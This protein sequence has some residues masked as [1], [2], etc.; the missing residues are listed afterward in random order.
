MARLRDRSRLD[1]TR[2]ASMTLELMIGPVA[3][4]GPTVDD[5]AV[6]WELRGEDIMSDYGGAGGNAAV[7]VLGVRCRGGEAVRLGCRSGAAG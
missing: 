5:L 7:G 2:L 3:G 4:Y 6:A 1:P